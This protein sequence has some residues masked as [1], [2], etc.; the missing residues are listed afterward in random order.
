MGAFLKKLD[1]KT[2]AILILVLVLIHLAYSGLSL[3][4]SRSPLLG[5]WWV[6]TVVCIVLILFAADLLSRSQ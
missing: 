1:D 4:F 3:M 5:K 2:E 6:S